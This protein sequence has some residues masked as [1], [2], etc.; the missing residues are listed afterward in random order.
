MG[1][2]AARPQILG[3]GSAIATYRDERGQELAIE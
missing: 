3:P 1:D 2:L